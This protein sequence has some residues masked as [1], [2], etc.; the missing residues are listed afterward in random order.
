MLPFDEVTFRKTINPFCI[1]CGSGRIKLDK[2]QPPFSI[3]E[4]YL[5]ISFICDK[6]KYAFGVHINIEP[7]SMIKDEI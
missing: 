6:C 7:V 5:V 3:D 2:E 4:N 1:G